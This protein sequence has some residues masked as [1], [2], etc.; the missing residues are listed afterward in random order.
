MTTQGVR[1]MDLNKA[2]KKIYILPAFLVFFVLFLL[3]SIL[4]LFYSFTN[5]NVMSDDIRFIGL[6]NY[7][8]LIH[9]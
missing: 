4:G 3:P 5:W 9:I 6:D 1:N 7:L 8:S 2:Y